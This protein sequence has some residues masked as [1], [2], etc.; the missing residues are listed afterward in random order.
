MGWRD[1]FALALSIPV[2]A[3]MLI[4]YS[5][6]ALGAWTAAALWGTSCIIAL[7]QNYLYAE[8]AAMFPDKPGGIAMYAH[9]AWKRYLEP[10]GP[11]AA[12]GYW[13]GWSFVLAVFSLIIGDLLTAQFFPDATWKV[14]DGLVEIGP[15]HLIAVA[16]IFCVWLLNIFGVK[17]AVRFN[18]LLGGV[19][20]IA[21]IVLLV[22][23]MVTGHWSSHVLS[24]GKLGETDQPWH[25]WQLALVYL[26]VMG[27]TSY[28]TEIGATMTPEYKDHKRDT[29]RVLI[30]SSLLSLLLLVG[31]VITT[32]GVSSSENAINN[33]PIGYLPTAFQTV[34][35]GGSIVMT[36]VIVAALF[37]MMTSST[38]DAGRALYGIAKDGMVIR[39]LDYLNK[40][41][42][43]SRAMTLDLVINIVLVLFVGN[44]LG[45]LFA[46]NL[47]YMLAIFFALVGFLLLRKDRPDWPRP[48]KRA[49]IWI[50]VA[51]V[52][53][54][55]TAFLNVL[56]IMYS[57]VAGY[58]SITDTL[59]G[60]AVLASS[61]V[62]W[63]YRRIVQ[64]R[65]PLRLRDR[66]Y[67]G[68]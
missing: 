52:L 1:G 14:S 44:T 54:A 7:L 65:Q 51:F 39:Q 34:L 30:S 24:W 19:A 67:I 26:Y 57:G 63:A 8:M 4:G 48:V 20:V 21:I 38:A 11:L 29:S 13:A 15:G 31:G 16:A 27:W 12:V 50:P 18:K 45:V 49:R 56:G 41:G 59:V 6:G 61:L 46:S 35:G 37:V 5:I 25:G 62:L 10:V 36:L 68:D 40:E 64:D 42:M 28:A 60:F 22:G 53:A 43:P 2:G 55:I 33:D 3:F 23:S 17:P 58:G 66:S 32:A 47:G 9:E